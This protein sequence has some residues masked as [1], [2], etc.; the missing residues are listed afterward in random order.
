QRSLLVATSQTLI[1]SSTPA[2][3]TWLP[4][5]LNAADITGSW[6]GRNW[7]RSL[8]DSTSQTRTC[9]LLPLSSS[10][11]TASRLPSDVRTAEVTVPPSCRK[12]FGS[13][14]A[15]TSQSQ[16][17]PSWLVPASLPAVTSQ[18]PSRLKLA[19]STAAG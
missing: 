5:G 10:P 17:A 8:A 19:W 4:S 12:V 6:S 3:T 11:T 2:E 1:E 18:R 7:T 15:R 9:P 13:P 14:L 16:A